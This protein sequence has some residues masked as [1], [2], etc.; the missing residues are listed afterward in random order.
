MSL[1]YSAKE[2]AAG[3]A[4]ARVSTVITIFSVFFL[5]FI[6][7]IVVIVTFNINRLVDVLNANQDVQVFLANTITNEEIDLLRADVLEM[8][9]VK[10]IDY[11]SKEEAAAEFKKEFGDDIFD[12]LEENPLPASFIIRLDEDDKRPSIVDDLAKRLERRPE[13]DQV[14][15]QQ[16][17]LNVLVQFSSVS[18]IVLYILLL[19]VFLGSL[20]MISNTIR[21][22]ILARQ[23]IINTMKLVGATD[24][25][26]RRPF[27][28]EGMFQGLLGGVL[29]FLLLYFIISLINLQ[30]PGLLYV[31]KTIYLGIIGTGLFFGY[32]GSQLAIRRFL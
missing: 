21:L 30:W 12:A 16:G 8:D 24:A 32:A 19:L 1:I 6:L 28:F 25:F 13:I 23:Q 18:R 5:L 31:P 14:I 4:K 3:F 27:L 26:I 29:A 9:G 2:A 22:I 20:F 10:S 11:I 15:K 7:G 17:T